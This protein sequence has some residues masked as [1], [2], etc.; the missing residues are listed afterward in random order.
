[1]RCWR[2]LFAICLAL[3]ALGIAGSPAAYADASTLYFPATGHFLD[4]TYGFLS[5]WNANH[6]D[7]VLGAPIAEASDTNGVVRQYFEGGRLEQITDEKTG[8]AS[9]RLGA[10]GSEYA[11]AL[12]KTFAAAPSRRG[13]GASTLEFEETGHTLREPFLSFW[14]SYGG[15][16]VFGA[17][18][19]EAY[20]E[21]TEHGQR[22]VQYFQNVRIERDTTQAGTDREIVVGDLGRA[23]AELMQIDTE[24]LANWGAPEYGP[25]APVSA[26]IASL[27]IPTATPTPVATPRPTPAPT[28]RAAAAKPAAKPAPA[29]KPKRA[30]KAEKLIVVNLSDQ[31]MYAYEDGEQVFSAPVSTGRDGMNTPEGTFSVYAKIKEQTMK[32]VLD[33]VPWK[34]PN[35]PNV[36]YFNGGVALHGTYWHN[37]FGT[38]ARLSHGCV[39]LPLKAAAWLYD[40][41]PMGTTVQVVS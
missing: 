36:M 8:E 18:I 32:G 29:E 21:L 41:A 3:G 1:M 37:R 35:V 28:P 31:W 17:P 2:F 12:W 4:D 33:G 23:L 15:E 9:I 16:D 24:R 34:V 39:N 22:L 27:D 13:A 40:W 14:Q 19:S 5:F 10:V 6:G 7:R 38:G 26:N 20:W 30:V 25:S 11:E